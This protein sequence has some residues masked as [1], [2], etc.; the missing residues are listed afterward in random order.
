MPQRPLLVTSDA[1]LLDELLRLCAAAGAEAQVAH[2]IASARLTWAAPPLVVIGSDLAEAA[3]AARLPRRTRVVLVGLDLHDVGIWDVAVDIGADSV[4]S[5]PDAQSWLVDRLG[6]TTDTEGGAG[7]VVAVVGGR[8]GAGATTLATALAVTG[9]DAGLRCL[10][11]DA[12][13]LG[14][15]I[16][17]V[18]GG[19]ECTGLRWPDLAAAGG[20]VSGAAL[21]EALPQLHGLSVLSAGRGD[22]LTVPAPAMRSVLG[23][24][25]RMSDLTV[26]DLPRTVD[27]AAEQALTVAS[28]TLLVVPAEVRAAAAAGRVA[29]AVGLTARDVRVVVRGPAPAGLTASVVA[30]TLAL[31]LAG[32]LAPEPRLD[33]ALERGEPPGRGGRSPLGSFCREL[34]GD[35]GAVRRRAA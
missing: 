8:G 1:E 34:L 17:L 3:T 31:P 27:A 6:E 28:V 13:P 10:L 12:D 11:V 18:L 14:G 32:W 25:A 30:D 4:V 7:L 35:L 19:E 16:D 23:A 24:A 20:R 29:V 2:D 15:G 26:V 33:E 22:A 9:A 21:R 5:L